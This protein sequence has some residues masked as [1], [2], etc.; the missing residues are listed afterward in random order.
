MRIFLSAIPPRDKN[1]MISKINA[2]ITDHTF[3]HEDADMIKERTLL[4]K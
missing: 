2:V 1:F 4:V 3:I